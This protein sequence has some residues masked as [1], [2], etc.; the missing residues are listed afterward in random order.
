MQM[1]PGRVTQTANRK[2]QILDAARALFLHSGFDGTSTD[3]IVKA[4]GISSKET[5]YRYFASKEDLFLAVIESMT[6][7]GPYLKE[8]IDEEPVISTDDELRALLHSVIKNILTT[9]LQPDYLALMRITIAEMP[10]FPALAKH[11][12]E[13]VPVRALAKLQL[14][15]KL[16]QAAGV[17]RIDR[18]PAITARMV[19]GTVLSYGVIDGL[20]VGGEQPKPPGPKIINGIVDNLMDI[21]SLRN[22]NRKEPQNGWK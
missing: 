16:G 1:K 14:L 19:L 15:L 5:L 7:E 21:V 9:M 17:A 22:Y 4:A 13:A 6:V 20:L 11:F 18:D 3:A 2:A 8:L 10:R 12:R